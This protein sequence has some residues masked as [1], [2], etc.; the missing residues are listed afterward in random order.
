MTMF[1]A[2]LSDADWGVILAALKYVSRDNRFIAPK[3]EGVLER[4][5]GAL[6]VEEDDEIKREWWQT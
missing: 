5:R 3:A 2:T 4:L 1:S 6:R